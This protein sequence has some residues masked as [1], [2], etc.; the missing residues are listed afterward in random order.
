MTSLPFVG[1]KYVGAVA[2]LPYSMTLWN[3]TESNMADVYLIR[4]T[5]LKL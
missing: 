3:N 5:L 4:K 1:V 2:T